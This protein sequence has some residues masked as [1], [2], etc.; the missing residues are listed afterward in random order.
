M[1][2]SV[3]VEFGGVQILKYFPFPIHSIIFLIYF[4]LRDSNRSFWCSRKYCYFCHE[5]AVSV[6]H[7]FFIILYFELSMNVRFEW[8]LKINLLMRTKWVWEIPWLKCCYAATAAHFLPFFFF[9]E[10]INLCIDLEQRIAHDAI[11]GIGRLFIS[12]RLWKKLP[13]F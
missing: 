7:S 12:V 9:H 5:S 13:W 10:K 3:M 1:D 4:N 11:E 8:S 2:S 6:V